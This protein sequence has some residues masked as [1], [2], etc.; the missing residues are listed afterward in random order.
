MLKKNSKGFTVAEIMMVVVLI[1]IIGVS[2]LPSINL[3]RKHEIKKIAKSL[4]LDLATQRMYAMRG[5]ELD[6]FIRLISHPEGTYY[7]TYEVYAVSDT[8]TEQDNIIRK[9]SNQV[10]ITMQTTQ[11][12][13]GVTSAPH[14]IQFNAYGE[15]LDTSTEPKG[16]Y[17]LEITITYEK[18]H[19]TITFDGI[20]GHYSIG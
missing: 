16:I 2:A 15:L 11:G 6:Y 9:H 20:T 4:C 13:V 17:K 1:S 7:Y 3:I 12:E 10:Q 18:L 8:L 5:D 14:T 19:T